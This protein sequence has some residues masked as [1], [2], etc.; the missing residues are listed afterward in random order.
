MYA[1]NVRLLTRHNRKKSSIIVVSL[2]PL[3][4]ATRGILSDDGIMRAG[5]PDQWSISGPIKLE[6]YKHGKLK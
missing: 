6:I 1:M 2:K 5:N 4:Q 3:T